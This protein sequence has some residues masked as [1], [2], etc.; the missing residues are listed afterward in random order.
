MDPS[1]H[2]PSAE[3]Y[4]YQQFC[5][6]WFRFLAQKRKREWRG[7]SDGVL[8]S[9]P[10][11]ERCAEAAL[12][13]CLLLFF[14]LI[15]VFIFVLRD[16]SVS[17]GVDPALLAGWLWVCVCL[18]LCSYLGVFAQFAVHLEFFFFFFLLEKMVGIRTLHP[19]LWDKS[20]PQNN[21]M[22]QSK[23]GKLRLFWVWVG[24]TSLWDFFFFFFTFWKLWG[25]KKR[26]D[27][28]FFVFFKHR[29]HLWKSSVPW[30]SLNKTII[31]VFLKKNLVFLS[32]TF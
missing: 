23:S 25:F 22:K 28:L 3:E 9:C 20:Q 24:I 12:Q 14:L 8:L 15:S 31:G 7:F 13:F 30:I 21:A 6:Y 26:S 1:L 16:G 2:K 17:W 27:V 19:M 5:K 29:I 11:H 32:L 10:Q 18:W 4:F